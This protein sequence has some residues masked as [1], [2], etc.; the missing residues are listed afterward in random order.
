MSTPRTFI[1]LLALTGV[2]AFPAVAQ[3]VRPADEILAEFEALEA[4]SFDRSKS[5]DAEWV[6][7][8]LA[9]KKAYAEGQAALIL[10]LWESHPDHERVLELVPRRWQALY[11]EQIGFDTVAEETARVMETMPHSPLAVEAAYHAATALGNEHRWDA[12]HT[13]PAVE[14]L[15]ELAPHDDRAGGL[16]MRVASYGESDAD[17]K[18]E[19]YRRVLAWPDSRNAGYAR[20]K[21]RQFE[22]LGQPFALS[23]EEARSGET[24]SMEDLRDKVVV[25]DFWATWCGPCVAEMP[26]MKELYAEYRDRGVE[27]IGVSLDQPVE[28]GGLDKLTAY[29]EE[30][31]I[32]WPQYYQ[33]DYWDSEFSKSWGIN[34]IP[35]VFVVDKGGDLYS[36]E[37][38]G[39]LDEM[40][41]E[42]LGTGS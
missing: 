9:A 12:G 7:Q 30:N 28:R 21:V 42:L 13:L 35:S 33:G 11:L 36:V 8:Y 14:R 31:G 3:D 1:T 15:I 2:L 37:A 26:H 38:R 34:S 22:G 23:F 10:E 41:P 27:F 25:V 4:P 19:L 20:G 6:A 39:K 18:L 5:D 40:I 17:R 24:I 32:D 16:L 29:V